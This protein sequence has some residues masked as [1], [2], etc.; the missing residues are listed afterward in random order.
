MSSLEESEKESIGSNPKMPTILRITIGGLSFK[1]VSSLKLS[2]TFPA[3][4]LKKTASTMSWDD[5]VSPKKSRDLGSG[6]ENVLKDPS[7]YT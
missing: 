5:Q 7:F 1:K 4:I 2:A 3:L 6:A